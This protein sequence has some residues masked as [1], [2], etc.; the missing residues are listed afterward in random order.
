ME[1]ELVRPSVKM[2]GEDGNAF[3]IIARCHRAAK[4]AGWT[5]E[6]WRKF[7][8]EAKSGDYDHLLCTVLDYFN[9]DEEESEEEL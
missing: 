5:Q 6:Q 9:V 4:K 2:L 7:S 1:A 3:F 8:E